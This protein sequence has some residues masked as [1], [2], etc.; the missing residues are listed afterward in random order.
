[1]DFH[2]GQNL[3]ISQDQ[4][5]DIHGMSQIELSDTQSLVDMTT[6]VEA[7]QQYTGIGT[8]TAEDLRCLLQNPEDLTYRCLL[9]VDYIRKALRGFT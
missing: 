9:Q 7:L 2:T 3:N 5:P 1:M 6:A 4:M 8:L